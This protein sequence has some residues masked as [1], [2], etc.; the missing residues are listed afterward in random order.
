VEVFVVNRSGRE[1]AMLKLH[2]FGLG[3]KSL[4]LLALAASLLLLGGCTTSYRLQQ[5][6]D[7]EPVGSAPAQFPTP[8]PPADDLTWTKQF[9]TSVVV[10][11]DTGG[12]WVRIQP[13]GTLGQRPTARA[14]LAFTDDFN[15]PGQNVR[16]HFTV[17]LVGGGRVWI[18]LRALQNDALA[19][20]WLGGYSIRNGLGSADV[21][22][23]RGNELHS[24][25]TLQS[26]GI[27]NGAGTYLAPYTPGQTVDLFWSIDQASRTVNLSVLPGENAQVTFDALT[28][29][30]VS[31]TPLRRLWI[32]IYLHEFDGS[33]VLFLDDVTVEEL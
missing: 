14:L 9:A 29:E 25:L 18:G 3:M 32:D 33:T 8:N 23:L 7:A 2:A 16:G 1:D 10:A 24:G 28:P 17:R 15:T 21:A 31:N 5:N 27:I 13:G 6:F 19:G 11:R 12:R 30:G 26:S 22:Y 4:H 20:S